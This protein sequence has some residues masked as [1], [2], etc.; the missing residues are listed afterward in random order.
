MTM[1]F[2]LNYDF[3]ATAGGGAVD[4]SEDHGEAFDVF[5]ADGFGRGPAAGGGN[6]IRDDAKMA[7][8]AVGGV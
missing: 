1:N 5:A 6:E 7:A 3:D 4:G 2:L 8:D